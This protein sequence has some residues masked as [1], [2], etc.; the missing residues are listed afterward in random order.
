[1]TATALR[2]FLTTSHPKMPN[3]IVTPEQMTDVI[4]YILSLHSKNVILRTKRPTPVGG[5][6]QRMRGRVRLS[7]TPM[8]L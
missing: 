6:H 1:M 4:A 2:V 5:Y 8:T 3:P 7:S